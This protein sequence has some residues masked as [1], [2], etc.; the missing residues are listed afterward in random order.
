MGE[1]FKAIDTRLGRAVAIKTIRQMFGARFKGEA[2]AISALNHPHICTLYDVGPNYLVMELLEGETLK[3]RITSGGLTNEELCSIGIQVSDALEAAHSQATIHRDIKPSNIFVTSRGVVK[4]LDFGLAKTI[5]F[6]KADPAD[7]G[8]ALT[9]QASHAGTLSYMSPEQSRG[10]DV[11]ARTDLFSLGVVLYE[12]ATGRLPFT[13]AS[14][15]EICDALLNR[16]PRSARELN[17]ELTPSLAQILDRALEKDRIQRYQTASDLHADLR[18]AQ[19]QLE[20][21]PADVSGTAAARSQRNYAVLAVGLIA[22]LLLLVFAA[23][24]YLHSPK[25]PVTNPA[26]YVQLTN[27]SDSAVAPSLSPDG[28]MVAFIRGG[29]PFLSS[30]QIYVKVLSNGESVRLS[31]VPNPKYGPV[32]TPDGSRV[33]YTEWLRVG[34]SFSWDTMTVS[35]VGGQPARFLSNASGLTWINDH[36][37]LFSEVKTGIHMGIVTTSDKRAESRDVY[38][39]LTS[40]AWRIIPIYLPTRSRF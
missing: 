5:G 27:F 37:L 29:S 34:A 4:L 28:R 15:T 13:G 36:R 6:T 26:E 33:A 38:P 1:V 22:I 35:V 8:D 39:P 10:W 21:G 7:H 17:P 3:E 11:D 16:N 20:S 24:R 9:E 12:M 32:F 2:Q 14:R 31:N 19:R 30:G 23:V 25:A 18:R 40:A